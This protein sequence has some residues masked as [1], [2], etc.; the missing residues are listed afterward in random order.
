MLLSSETIKSAKKQNAFGKFIRIRAL[1]KCD[2][3]EYALKLFN[4][5]VIET[6][7]C[8]GQI[9]RILI[10]NVYNLLGKNFTECVVFDTLTNG[11]KLSKWL[12]A[13]GVIESKG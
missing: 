13:S 5:V 1:E 10:R 12:M 9:G 7:K 4:N 11:A 6:F 3:P 2:Q 8:F